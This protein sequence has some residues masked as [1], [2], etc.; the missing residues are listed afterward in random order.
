V[1][2]ALFTA[3]AV[4]NSVKHAFPVDRR[5]KGGK[6]KVSYSVGENEASLAIEDDGVGAEPGATGQG[7]GA[8]LMNAFAKQVHGVF[9]DLPSTSSGRLV[10]IIIP[11]I[12]G[13]TGA[14]P[15]PAPPPEPVAP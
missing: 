12:N 13:V 9:E 4:T 15:P 6:V 8:T 7:I 1:P 2:L 11:R 5:P 14:R 3:E 10:R